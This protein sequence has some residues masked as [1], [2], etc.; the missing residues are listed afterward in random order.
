[1]TAIPWYSLVD[2]SGTT[3]TEIAAWRYW[4]GEIQRSTDT[5]ISSPAA[6]SR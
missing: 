2:E 1:M 5:E 4:A 3:V 6:L